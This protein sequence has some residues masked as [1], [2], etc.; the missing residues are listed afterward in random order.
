VRQPSRVAIV[1][2]TGLVG[3]T[4]LTVLEERF[5]DLDEVRPLAESGRGRTVRFAGRSLEVRPIG[6]HELADADAVFLAAT[7]AVSERWGPWCAARGALVVDKSSRFRL[8]PEVP[9]VV[10]E[11]NGHLVHGKGQLVASPN[12]STIQLVIPLHALLR[13]REIGRV[14][15]STYQAVSG[16]GREAVIQLEDEVAAD[17]DGGAPEDAGAARPYQKPIAYNVLAQCDRF[18]P[19]GYTLEEW[20]LTQESE[21]ILGRSLHVSATAVRVPVRVGHAEA[22]YVELDRPVEVAEVREWFAATPGLVVA[23]DPAAGVYP[24]PRDAAGTDAVYV[25]RIRRDLHQPNGLHLFIVSDNLRKGAATNAVQILERSLSE[26]PM[27]S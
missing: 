19:E 24:T 13:H 14:L 27:L 23:D 6:E 22:V 12:C 5:P 16:T 21:K 2:A 10:P 18:G 11:V 26:E 25:G 3:Q 4:L 7:S 9:L 1:G 15:V 20:K 17:R 8:D